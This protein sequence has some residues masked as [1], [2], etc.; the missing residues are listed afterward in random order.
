MIDMKNYSNNVQCRASFVEFVGKLHEDLELN[1]CDWENVSL[2]D[3]LEALGRWTEDMDGYYVKTGREI[4][5]NVSWRIFADIL[6]AARI[7]E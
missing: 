5:K 4:P 1:P 7:Y 6:M 3:F 2:S